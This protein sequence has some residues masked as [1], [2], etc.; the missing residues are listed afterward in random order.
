MYHSGFLFSVQCLPVQIGANFQHV[1]TPKLLYCPR[2]RSKNVK[3]APTTTSKKMYGIR[4]AA[5]K[6]ILKIKHNKDIIL[7]QFQTR[8]LYCNCF[9]WR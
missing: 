5:G 3:G 9:G 6:R 8:V 2:E 1:S 4:K 7:G